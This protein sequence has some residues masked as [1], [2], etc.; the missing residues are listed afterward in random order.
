MVKAARVVPTA[1]LVVA[2]LAAGGCGRHLQ[3]RFA[4]TDQAPTVALSSAL[5]APA[6]SGGATHRLS[7]AMSASAGRVDHFLVTN[8]LRSLG[9]VDGS[10]LTTTERSQRLACPRATPWSAAPTSAKSPDFRFFAVRAVDERGNVSPPAFRAFFGENVAPTVRITSPRP[11][12]LISPNVSPSV[13]I[14]WEGSDPDGPHGRPAKYKFKLIPATD[15]AFR[16]YLV[17][18]DSIRRQFAP[19]FAGW[20]SI[21]G[22]STRV[23]LTGLQGNSQC[24]FALTALDAG[25]A[26]D[27]VFN[28]DKNVLRMYVGT[29]QWPP[30]FTLFNESFTYVYPAGGVSTDSVWAVH[31]KIPAERSLTVRWFASPAVGS[32]VTGYRWALDIPDIDEEAPRTG[33]TDRAHWSAWGPVTS[34]TVGP[35]TGAALDVPHR[36]Y[37]E[38]LDDNDALSLGIVEFRLVRQPHD[39]DLLIVNDTRFAADQVEPGHPDSLSAPSGP[40]PNAAELDTFLFAVGGARWRMTPEGTLSPRGIFRG[41][42]YDTIGTRRGLEDPTIPLDVLGRYRHVVWLTDGAGSKWDNA[43]RSLTQPTTTLRYMAGPNHLNTLATW[44]EGGGRL[45]SLGGGFGNATSAPWNNLMNETSGERVYSSSGTRPDLTPGRFMYDLAHWRSEFRFAGPLSV[46]VTRA[47]FPVGGARGGPGYSRLPATLVSKREAGDPLPPLRDQTTF[48]APTNTHYLE[49]L[50]QPNEIPG[51]WGAS[52][53]GAPGPS[54]LDTLMVATGP[55]L[56][57]QGADPAMDRVVNPVM[58][59]YHG[60]DH[61]SVVFSGFDAWSWSRADCVRLVDVVLGDVWGLTKAPEVPW[62]S[63]LPSVAARRT[64]AGRQER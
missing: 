57:P 19:A 20:D 7:W 10:W 1:L 64:P 29:Y 44:V 15:P 33:P 2:V 55:A 36:L 17:D 22:D 23:R 5:E 21:S 59:C 4:A 56:P 40:W 6:D 3:S 39:R 51:D 42:S 46:Q 11:S 32:L 30:S 48:Y 12:S 26:Y 60:R 28:F 8:D 41:Y 16:A 18:P 31:I 9:A 54:S 53:R 61:G 63:R 13:W 24:V 58:T 35:F 38:A 37:V 45:W 52:V 27:P 50:S 47:P 25:G 34:A 49:Y 14:H 62:G 43:P